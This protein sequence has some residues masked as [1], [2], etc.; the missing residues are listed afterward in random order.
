MKADLVLAL[1]RAHYERNETFFHSLV[2]QAASHCRS[3]RHKQA[4]RTQANQ[5]R[6]V[7]L[8]SQVSHLVTRLPAVAIDDLVLAPALRAELETLA[9]EI[10]LRQGLAARGLPARSRLLFHGPPGNGKTALA[11]ALGRMLEVQP[12]GVNLAGL[13]ESHL[14]ETGKNLNKLFEVLSLGSFLVVDEID[15]IGATRAAGDGSGGTR[16]FNASVNVMLTLFDRVKDGVLVGLTNRIEMLDPALRRRF[17]HAICIEPP[18]AKLA[19]VL[20]AK[21]CA[22]YGIDETAVDV[23][24]WTNFDDI[25]K[26]VQGVARR[27]VMQEIRKEKVKDAERAT[28]AAVVEGDSEEDEAPALESA[29]GG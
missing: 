17:D 25:V 21:L 9:E 28:N 15:A 16:E 23:V 26:A 13:A 18:T 6:V 12:Y 14:G 4:L 20:T 5:M 10:R 22:R 11:S 29:A 24:E 1:V 7:E 8:P 19:G 2:L 27:I 3:E